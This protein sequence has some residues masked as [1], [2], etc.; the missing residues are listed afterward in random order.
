MKRPAMSSYRSLL[1]WVLIVTVLLS[2]ATNGRASVITGILV[3][4]QAAQLSGTVLDETGA[5]VPNVKITVMNTTTG[6]EK[7]ITTNIDGYFL[8]PLLPPGE[9][10]LSAEVDGFAVQVSEALLQA[11][12]NSSFEIRLKP[13]EIKESLVVRADGEIDAEQNHINID[14]ATLSHRLA[15]DRL[16]DVPV[17]STAFGRNGMSVFPYMVPGIIPTNSRGSADP[18]V[19]RFGSAMS[20]NGSRPSSIAFN[21]EGADNNDHEFN[22]AAASLPNPDALEEFTII[23]GNYQADQGRSSGGIVNATIKSGTKKFSGNARSFL[24]NEV[25]NAR[26]FFDNNVPT[27][28]LSVFGGQLGGP[29]VIPGA[30]LDSAF[31]FIDYESTRHVR[32]RSDS[33]IVPSLK[34]RRG[35]FSLSG[36]L[37]RDPLTL[38]LF[39]QGIIPPNRINPI[40]VLVLDRFIP[41]PNQPNNTYAMSI[42]DRGRSD[43]ITSRF[44]WK[45]ASNDTLSGTLFLT[46]SD[47]DLGRRELP[48]NSIDERVSRTRN[49]VLRE[50]HFF[51]KQATNEVTVSFNRFNNVRTFFSPGG[52]GVAPRELGFTG[53]RPQTTRFITPPSIR[54]N[55]DLNIDFGSPSSTLLN[56]WQIKDDFSYVHGS[57]SLKFGQ[58]IRRFIED[59]TNAN[60]SGSF[61]FSP[62]SLNTIVD[63]A[64]FL[65]ALPN[66]YTQTTGNHINP[67]QFASYSYAMDD[68]RVK[69]NLTVNLGLRYEVIPPLTDSLDQLTVFRP[70]ITS[71]RFPGAPEGLLFAG[72]PDP[73][74]GTVPRGVYPTDKNNFAPRLGV[75]YSPRGHSGWLKSIFG[76]G[77]TAIRAGAGVYYDQT[78]GSSFT[79]FSF[80]QPFS[81]SQ[82]LSANHFKGNS[83][84]F[85]A[86]FGSQNV[87]P[88]DLSKRRFTVQ[89]NVHTLDPTFRTAYSYH[90]NLTIQRELPWS[91]F[92]E[93]GFVG[94][95]SFKLNQRRELNTANVGPGA[96][97][98]NVPERRKYRNLGSVLSQESAGRAS[99]NSFQIRLARRSRGLFLDGWYVWGKSLDL[100]SSPDSNSITNPFRWGRSSFDRRHNAV[101][102]YQYELPSPVKKGALGMVLSGW[103]IGGIT[104]LR[105]GL[106]M[107]I[108]Q[109]G[110]TTLTGAVISER[111]SLDFVGPYRRLDPRQLNTFIFGNSP[112]TGHFFFDPTAFREVVITNYTDARPGNL[113]RNVFDGPGINLTSMAL[114]KR[115][116]ITESNSLILRADVRNVF[117]R[118]HFDMPSVVSNFTLISSRFGQVT[119]AAPGRN[120][121]LS[122]KYN[123]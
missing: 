22:R 90:Y 15:G 60:N 44:D 78:F 51:S 21:L 64:D 100:G 5:V 92:L 120:I 87:F 80:V 102:T 47:L 54:I 75:A 10:L 77:R 70:G 49:L 18:S 43:Q 55:N 74:L 101:I 113:G 86:P 122:L 99:Y 63:F 17:W 72:D 42:T 111:G 34:E 117:N 8:I 68:W 116:R 93:A 37:P 89:P 3:Q 61:V 30:S 36:R 40:S 28:R 2:F 103:Q 41:L 83:D 94:V 97:L 27:E 39:P 121:Q 73:I 105:S 29:I 118:A 46:S 123:F 16:T 65:L 108:G 107:D 114:V 69:P 104:E 26:G 115:L 33:L 11:G 48:I 62:G 14:N 98:D 71:T 67:G 119:T 4:V 13:K 20:I 76:E 91:V 88:I 12:T 84:R 25:L 7:N 1:T 56:T 66:R 112:V 23:T 57:H 96:R 31:F 85:A 45:V 106:P 109:L 58:E 19:N 38:R 59:S 35:D 52:T 50:T 32:E 81:V 24:I 95:D 110:D 6:I 9:Y 53:I 79:Q 82:L